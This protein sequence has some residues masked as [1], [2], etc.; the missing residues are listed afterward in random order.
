MD[1]WI[2]IHPDNAERMVTVLRA[3][4]FDTLDL[5]PVAGNKVA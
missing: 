5:Y 3:F 4:G 1:I 2:A